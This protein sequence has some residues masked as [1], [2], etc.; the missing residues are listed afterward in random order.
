MNIINSGIN[1]TI[2]KKFEGDVYCYFDA[3]LFFQN[4]HPSTNNHEQFSNWP[5]INLF[6]NMWMGG[7]TRS[8]IGQTPTFI[9]RVIWRQE[10]SSGSQYLGT[11]DIMSQ[12]CECRSSHADYTG[13]LLFHV[14]VDVRSGVA[15]FS[16]AIINLSHDSLIISIL[17]LSEKDKRAIQH[18]L[19]KII[20]TSSAW[21]WLAMNSSAY[22]FC[23]TQHS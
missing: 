7:S 6:N 12:C 22:D 10:T 1:F 19:L 11:T 5:D 2:I 8:L 4:L 23:S 20:I 3:Y 16:Y 14:L 18:I 17:E 13:G 15:T 9:D 21:L